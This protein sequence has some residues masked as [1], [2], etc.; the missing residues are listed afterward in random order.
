MVIL[1]S[2]IYTLFKSNFVSNLLRFSAVNGHADT[3][4]PLIW[5][6]LMILMPIF[7]AATFLF[8]LFL[9]L[10]SLDIKYISRSSHHEVLL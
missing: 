4:N 9:Q 5:K 1:S 3:K 8:T 10:I 7:M 2:A 6:Q